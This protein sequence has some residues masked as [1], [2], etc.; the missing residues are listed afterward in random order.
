M[1]DYTAAWQLLE[2]FA[3]KLCEPMNDKVD[4]NKTILDWRQDV[5]AMHLE[6]IQF[7]KEQREQ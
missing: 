7:V 5:H 1:P 3:E 2:K 4:G 6:I